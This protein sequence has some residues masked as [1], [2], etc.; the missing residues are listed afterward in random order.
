MNVAVLGAGTEGRDIALLCARA[1]HAVNLQAADATRAMDRIDDIER[2][3]IDA[4]ASKEITEETKDQ[5]I[6]DLQAT[7]DLEA[8]VSDAAVV[9]DTT[10]KE[11]EQLQEL[12]AELESF[13]ERE[14]LITTSSTTASVTTVAAGLRQPDRAIGFHF[15]DLGSPSV[16]EILIADQTT[17]DAAERAESFIESLGI[18]PVRVRDV[19]GFGS[20]RLELALEVEAMRAI[21]DGVV[22]VEGIDTLAREGMQHPMGP[23]ER[24]DR[25]GL[26]ARLETLEEFR[27][28]LGDRY[29]PPEIL[30]K[31]VSAGKTG[32]SVGEGFYT[33]ESGEPMEVA[34]SEPDIPERDDG[35]DDPSQ[36]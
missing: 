7:T 15:F 24:A 6:D 1:G 19:P 28:A 31:R 14:T 20:T 9:I 17:Q 4:A 2:G 3:L 35:P 34:V 32:S 36:R 30:R 18:T 10:E 11:S 25:A 33:W 22:G 5:A 29:D 8:A 12:F 23:L 27:E 21:D 13:V 16:V 26:D